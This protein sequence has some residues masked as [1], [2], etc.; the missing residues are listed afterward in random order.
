MSCY[1]ITETPLGEVAIVEEES[2]I[3]RLLLSEEDF[4]KWKETAPMAEKQET[5][6]LK[7]AKQQLREYFAGDRK[8]FSLPLAQKGTSFQQKV[9]QALDLIPYGESRSYADIAVAVGSPKAV[10]AVGQANKRN[11]LPIFVPCHRV[12]GKNRALTGYAGSRTNVKAVLLRIE[13]I[14]YKEK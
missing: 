11:A 7:E 6:I 10:R 14:P 5:P 9:W 3:T 1:E 2:K 4:L 8:T 12:I 13:Q